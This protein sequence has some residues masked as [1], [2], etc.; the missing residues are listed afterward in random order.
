[1]N[2]ALPPV[3]SGEAP[4]KKRPDIEGLRALAV[5]A[6]LLFH[7]EFVIFGVTFGGGFVGVD[8]FFVI[9]GFLIGG[10]VVREGQAGTFRWGHYLARRVRRIVPVMLLVLIVVT[11]AATALLL[12]SELEGYA[13][14]LGFSATFAANFHFWLNRGTY[15]ASEYEVLLHM[16]TLGVEAQFYLL[17]PLLILGLMRFGK[18]A[19][20]FGIV[21]I[22]CFSALASLLY[23]AASFYMLP[24]RLWE[25]ILGV[26]IALTPLPFVHYRWVREGLGAAGFALIVYAC[27]TFQTDTP[28]PGWRASIPCLGAAAIIAAGSHGGSFV[29][30]LLSA[31][32]AVF[33]G[34]ISYS[35]YLWHWPVI[36]LLL[37]GLPARELDLPLQ[38][39][40]AGLSLVLAVLSWRFVEEPLRK[41]AGPFR[42]V[43]ITSGITT[44]A[45][46][47]VAVSMIALSGWPARY[48]ERSLELAAVMEYPQ[49]EVFRSGTCFI[50]HRNQT[51]NRDACLKQ[52]AG[53]PQVL[54]IGDSHAA[55]LAPGLISAFPGSAVS[56]VTAAG[57]RPVINQ[58]QSAYPSCTALINWAYSGYLPFNQVDLIVLAGFWEQSDVPALG[59]TIRTLTRE[60]HEVLLVGPAAE[61]AQFVPRLLVLGE[62]RGDPGLADRMMTPGRGAMD[63]RMAQL[64]AD[65]GVPY[66]SLYRAECEPACR[67]LDAEN[68]PLVFDNSHFT[69]SASELFA[70]QIQHRALVR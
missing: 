63:A 23:P 50:H 7:L 2:P 29:G 40:A 39:L 45:L 35:L 47:A 57:C 31:A 14:S 3:F 55:H 18:R 16:W 37:L 27:I 44:A 9:S 52:S 26:L 28:F 30:R 48:S 25:F 42:P 21:I 11:L 70:G 19:L 64:A 8:V 41:P 54:L 13:Q 58:P 51:F 15:A 17:V 1:L 66:Y 59:A 61:W 49:D 69:L 34:K 5:I 4:G 22:A 60:G 33:I 12:P 6:V 36:V 53:K 32:P 38:L 46:C 65:T 24:A 62:E 56:Q 67:Y 20:W 68:M 10:I 43:L